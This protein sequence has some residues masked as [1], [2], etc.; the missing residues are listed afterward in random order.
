M[1]EIISKRVKY[2]LSGLNVLGT[3]EIKTYKKTK[4]ERGEWIDSLVEITT[5]G[6]LARDVIDINNIKV[7]SI[8]GEY[9]AV[10][11][12]RFLITARA[13]EFVR[14]IFC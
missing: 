4:T 9:P 12:G 14:D 6:I 7:L 1:Q 13:K 5:D 8:T 3:R 2:I 10:I 11:Q